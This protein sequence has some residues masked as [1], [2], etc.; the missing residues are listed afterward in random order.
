MVSETSVLL[1]KILESV[2]TRAEAEPVRRPW[3]TKA[4]P[5]T[6]ETMDTPAAK[7]GIMLQTANRMEREDM[8][9][10]KS[11]ERTAK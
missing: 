10:R 5:L 7:S 9:I 2:S 6:G 3:P 1:T 8:E 11:L 4:A